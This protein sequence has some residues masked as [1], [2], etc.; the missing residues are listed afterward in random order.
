LESGATAE[1]RVLA[2]EKLDFELTPLA[3]TSNEERRRF[4]SILTG[5]QARG[6]AEKNEVDVL[7]PAAWGH[8]LKLQDPFLREEELEE[9]LL[10]ELSKIL[11]ERAEQY[12]YN[13]RIE[14][15]GGIHVAVI[16]KRLLDAVRQAVSE[17]G[18]T[19]RGVFFQEAPFSA[20]DLTQTPVPPTA[21]RRKP[22]PDAEQIEER[23][24]RRP[25]GAEQP[26]WFLPT[27]LIAAA[28]VLIAFFWWRSTREKPAAPVRP[29]QEETALPPQRQQE[30]GESA[31]AEEPTA[32]P[33]ETPVSPTQPSPAK[34]WTGL[35]GR[36]ALLQEILGKTVDHRK[37]DLLSFTA[38]YFLLEISAPDSAEMES[39]FRKVE[40][41]PGITIG[42]RQ[43]AVTFRGG[44][45]GTIC[46]KIETESAPPAQ[47][48][49]NSERIYELA[50]KHSL[51]RKGMIFTGDYDPVIRFAA[52]CAALD[53]AVYRMILI[54]W[55]DQQYRIVFEP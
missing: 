54:P 43:S 31:Q 20:I 5:L 14:E 3:L 45:V 7:I 12:Q 24:P 39:I 29:P 47:N 22:L 17:S 8:T 13:Y 35:S 27:L 55:K 9:H 33:A 26:A 1:E 41:L 37:F 25:R 38:G 28:V 44:R 34:T 11:L 2:E 10:W 32:P 36:M 16:R 19:L 6:S 51:A 21:T 18:F 48:P 46:G 30:S 40:Q 50:R 15:D 23:K 42:A 53:F 4:S 49:P 52:D